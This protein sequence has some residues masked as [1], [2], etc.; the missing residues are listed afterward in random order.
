MANGVDESVINFA[1]YEDG[2]IYLGV[3]TITMPDIESEVFTTSGA[4]IG[5]EIEIPVT[6]YCSPNKTLPKSGGIASKFCV[7]KRSNN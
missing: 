2:K 3:A 6:C 7:E 1:L 4:A 5:G